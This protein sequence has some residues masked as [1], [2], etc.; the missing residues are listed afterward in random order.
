MDSLTSKQCKQENFGLEK[1]DKRSARRA[2]DCYLYLNGLGTLLDFLQFELVDYAQHKSDLKF[3]I[4]LA[5][6]RLK[7]PKRGIICSLVKILLI[8]IV[9]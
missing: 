5:C 2:T 8:Q 9:H 6:R 3:A 4:C 7:M 1:I